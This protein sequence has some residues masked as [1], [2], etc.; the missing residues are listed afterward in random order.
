[1]N[2]HDSYMHNK[3]NRRT[4]I[5]NAG[6][7][8]AILYAMP[9]GM[10]VCRKGV[11]EKLMLMRYDTEWWG[12]PAEMAGFLE[13][14][15]KVHRQ[16]EIPVTMFCRGF[17]LENM[18]LEFTAFHQETADDP[19][20]DMQDHSYSHVGLGYERGKPV[21]ILEADYERSFQI[22]SEIF[23]RRPT[24]IAICGT[25]DDGPFLPGFDAT[26]K[27]KAEFEMVVKLGTRMINSNLSGIDGSREFINYKLLGHPEVMG[28][29]S[30]YSD[31]AWMYRKE[32][33][34]P[35]EYMLKEVRTRSEQNEHM[36]VMFHDWVAWQKAPDKELSHV[37]EIAETGRKLGYT[38]V[39]HL[40]CYHNKQLWQKA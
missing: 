6:L 21:D 3:M 17:T 7:I 16:D 11:Q 34:D 27:S 19:L 12:E 13:K 23:G 9:A 39:T 20:F 36:P 40:D 32:Y 2:R 35:V 24:G 18:K 28:F 8:T 37:R 4:F 26:E 33:G 22:H 29:V 1:M 15:V 30:G 31:T 10:A 25:S 38:L 14:L 5:K